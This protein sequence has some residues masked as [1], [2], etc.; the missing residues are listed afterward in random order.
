MKEAMRW[1]QE[2]GYE[3]NPRALEYY[4]Q[5]GLKK[6]ITLKDDVIDKPDKDERDNK[7]Q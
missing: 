4:I 2:N 1:V 7:S 5:Y 3:G 6:K